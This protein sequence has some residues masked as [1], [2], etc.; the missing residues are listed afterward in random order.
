MSYDIRIMKGDDPYSAPFEPLNVTMLIEAVNSFPP[1][2]ERGITWSNER[3]LEY[4]P[5]EGLV[6][7]LEEYEPTEAEL[8]GGEEKMGSAD[9][10]NVHISYGT[11][12][13]L[14]QC[15]ALAVRIA[16]ATEATAWDLQ[17]DRRLELRD[18]VEAGGRFRSMRAW[19]SSIL[20]GR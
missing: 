9:A 3:W 2:A 8:G 14:A 15:I 18:V 4:Q 13:D 6:M 19:L 20:R 16:E 10:C 11:E 5:W 17:L 7:H 1:F 12:S